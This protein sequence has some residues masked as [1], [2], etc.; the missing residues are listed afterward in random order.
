MAQ[1]PGSNARVRRA[2]ATAAAATSDIELQIQQLRDDIATLAR[3]VATVG[4][5]KADDYRTRVRKATN[6]AAD[7]S[8]QMVEAAREQAI[9][10]EKDLERKIRTNPLQAVAIAAGVGFVIALLARR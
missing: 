10:L 6:D 5:E 2:T 3:S 4:S 8:L 7:A 1:D 9:S